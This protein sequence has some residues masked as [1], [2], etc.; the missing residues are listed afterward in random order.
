MSKDVIK[1]NFKEELNK[2]TKEELVE[3]TYEIPAK[4]LW[5]LQSNYMRTLQEK[6]GDPVAEE[7]EIAAF[8]KFCE[9]ETYR[10]KRFFNL[11]DD[12]HA[13]IKLNNYSQIWPPQGEMEWSEI[14]EKRACLRIT[15]CPMQV[16][17]RDVLGIH[18]YPCK[19]GDMAIF[20]KI[21]EVFNPNMSI[22]CVYAP[23][24]E[25]PEDAWCEWVFEIEE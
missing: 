19:K 5:T 20:R 13:F 24:D 2:L 11:G 7:F 1:W 14:T 23:P 12:M 16:S 8:G 9:V 15:R 17:R 4:S 21:A 10:L 25:H 22:T 3:Y 18:E 6:Y